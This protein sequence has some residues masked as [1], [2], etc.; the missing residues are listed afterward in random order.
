MLKNF[1]SYQMAKDLYRN[2]TK[3]K[4]KYYM[5]NQV[6][7]AA[8]SVVLNLREGAGR[9]KTREKARFYNIALGSL[10]EVQGVLDL[11]GKTNLY[12]KA[13]HLGA[14]IYNLIEATRKPY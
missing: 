6:E 4:S 11:L 14:C 12:K 8:L 7:R 9:Q 5:Q 10:R 13:D 1:R 3:I 2:V